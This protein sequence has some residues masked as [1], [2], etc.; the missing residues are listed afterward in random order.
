MDVVRVRGALGEGVE[1]VEAQRRDLG[2]RVAVLLRRKARARGAEL[3]LH[4]RSDAGGRPHR[5]LRGR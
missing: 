3:V 1:N 2:Q 4:V 5:A